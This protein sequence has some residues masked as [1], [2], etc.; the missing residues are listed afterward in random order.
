MNTDINAT[1]AQ[2][3]GNLMASIPIAG[4]ISRNPIAYK[5]KAPFRAWMLRESVAWRLLDLLTQSH[6]LHK[7]DH[8]LGARILLRSAFETLATLIYLNQI[9]RQVLD[10]ALDFNAFGDK[11]SV[12]LLGS[13][14]NPDGLKSMNIMTVLEKCAKEY[15]GLVTLYANLSESSHPS[16]EGLLRGYSKIGHDE[17][18]THFSN[19]WT[20]RYGHR[21]A[22]QITLCMETFLHEYNT[23]W[24]ALMTKLEEWIEM[25]DERLEAT[26]MDTAVALE[27]FPLPSDMRAR[28]NYDVFPA[29]KEADPLV[30]F[31]ATPLKNLI[32]IQTQGFRRGTDVGGKL[33]SVSYATHSAVSLDHWISHRQPGVDGAIIMVKFNSLEGLDVKIDTVYDRKAVPTQP[34]ILGYVVV[35][36]SYV[37]S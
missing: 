34:T 27:E 26:N 32:S 15:P 28:E 5:W 7:Q 11:T 22:E 33:E 37:H 14:N 31:H 3:R 29:E 25:N 21:S 23:V 6:A 18:E 24:P 19:R 17:Y 35:P 4:L 1:L 12:L 16:Y 8:I 30:L 36:A 13:R 9:M 10:S 20:E 2:W